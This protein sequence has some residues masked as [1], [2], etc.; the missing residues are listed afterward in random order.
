M[1]RAQLAVVGFSFRLPGTSREQFWDSLTAGRHLVTSVEGSR[2]S[3]EAFLHP[4]KAEPGRAYTFAA[5]SLGDVAAFDA[6]FFGISPREAGQMDPQQRILLELTWEALEEGEIR[7]SDLSGTR[8]GVY[9]GISS[10]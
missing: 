2:W 5:G 3:Q 7:P 9:V 8:M 4:S 10:I 6:G 1:Q